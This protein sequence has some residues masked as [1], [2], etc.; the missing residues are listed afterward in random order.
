ML[1]GRT[2]KTLALLIDEEDRLYK[3]P[4]SLSAEFAQ[5]RIDLEP[6][7]LP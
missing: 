5:R 3:M 1:V 2:V 6:K 4:L 7:K